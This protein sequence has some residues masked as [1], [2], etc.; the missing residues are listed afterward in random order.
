MTQN[1]VEFENEWHASKEDLAQPSSRM[2]RFAMQKLGFK[3]EHS[4]N[5]FLAIFALCAFILS[6]Y[7]FLTL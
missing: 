6:L 2:A 7:I 3:S 5:I 1:R 4:A